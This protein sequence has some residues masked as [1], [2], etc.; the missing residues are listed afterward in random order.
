MKKVF[1]F[2]VFS[3]TPLSFAFN[4][5]VGWGRG[6]TIDESLRLSF[7]K[8]LD[9][10]ENNNAKP[11]YKKVFNNL[12]SAEQ[13]EFTKLLPYLLSQFP[14]EGSVKVAELKDE[15]S[16][17][18]L[19][20]ISSS[21]IVKWGKKQEAYV[22][23]F[24]DKYNDSFPPDFLNGVIQNQVYGSYNADGITKKAMEICL[25]DNDEHMC[26]DSFNRV[27]SR[28]HISSTKH[29]VESNGLD[30]NK[31]LILDKGNIT[32]VKDN[33]LLLS[34]YYN[35]V[36]DRLIDNELKDA[37]PITQRQK[38]ISDKRFSL[39]VDYAEN[40]S[41]SM[42]E[43]FLRDEVEILRNLLQSNL[44]DKDKAKFASE[45][46]L[47]LENNR[48]ASSQ[49]CLYVP[50]VSDE[51]A[52]L[53]NSLK[54]FNDSL[55]RPESNAPAEEKE[56]YDVC[57]AKVSQI[58]SLTQGFIQLRKDISTLDERSSNSEERKTEL[59]ISL[60]KKQNELLVPLLGVTNGICQDIVSSDSGKNFLYNIF[61]T[62]GG[63]LETFGAIPPGATG[64]VTSS[65]SFLSSVGS[66]ISDLFKPD[67]K[68]LEITD[69]KRSAEDELSDFLAD[70]DFLEKACY[71]QRLTYTAD[72]LESEALKNALFVQKKEL[73]TK[74]E[75]YHYCRDKYD[76][77][78]N[79]LIGFFQNLIN[80][81]APD[82]RGG[83]LN[84]FNCKTKV[85]KFKV[86]FGSYKSQIDKMLAEANNISPKDI[87][88]NVSLN[89]WPS[90][91]KSFFNNDSE[92]FC[93]NFDDSIPLK[94]YLAGMWQE[95]ENINEN[96]VNQ[97]GLSRKISSV[98]GQLD[99]VNEQLSG[100]KNQTRGN[101]VVDLMLKN[102][103]EKLLGSEGEITNYLENKKEDIKS[104]TSKI[105]Q[106][107]SSGDQDSLKNAC[108]EVRSIRKN[109]QELS[110][111]CNQF[112]TTPS[113][114]FSML[115]STGSDNYTTFSHYYKG[116]NGVPV[117]IDE[118]CWNTFG[119]FD[120]ETINYQMDTL[121]CR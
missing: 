66:R 27:L 78:P 101:E 65:L 106:M 29:L 5:T 52:N 61:Q 12:N 94:E 19:G 87:A 53:T 43:F 88:L 103:G 30:K 51:F 69:V 8:A 77:L 55:P 33:N 102:I 72:S 100:S 13:K 56:K 7:E 47:E 64:I 58:D 70:K 26:K 91:E 116:D 37:R 121:G 89:T 1:L 17:L 15:H 119:S 18:G 105:S 57:G 39:L 81:I 6:G 92:E 34:N 110:Q 107:L 111:V 31:D 90:Y 42:P 86:V 11:N 80:G 32:V 99:I 97:G 114:P 20:S 118:R 120:H 74:R 48:Y 95:L 9:P 21:D 63:G 83:R 2:L 113:V 67:N 108:K 98:Q 35:L 117:T 10:K 112:S 3:I 75:I 96:V 46:L 62:I 14:F 84:Q 68:N 38:V 24:I 82:D 79:D 23:K 28:I 104:K 73:E 76:V 25:K 40:P 50:S 41:S 45:R 4:Q 44:K 59:I 36:S 115:D 109:M 93:R 60:E 54:E 49:K 16:V 71:F 85:D 22:Q